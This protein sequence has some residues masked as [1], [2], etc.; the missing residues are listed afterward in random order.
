M[1]GLQSKLR[2]IVHFNT[3]RCLVFLTETKI[4]TPLSYI[5]IKHN[6][7]FSAELI[8]TSE[9]L[10]IK[11]FQ[12]KGDKMSSHLA[13][14]YSALVYYISIIKQLVNLVTQSI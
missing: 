13:A 11:I 2:C 4:K 9:K 12:F 1:S 10:S 3:F 7:F 8:K 5:S 6:G 14:S